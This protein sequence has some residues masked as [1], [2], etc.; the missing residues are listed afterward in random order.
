MGGTP[1][2]M[3]VKS[4]IDLSPFQVK[5]KDRDTLS[6]GQSAVTI[7]GTIDGD[8]L[9]GKASVRMKQGRYSNHTLP[10]VRSSS[11]IEYGKEETLLNDLLI[12]TQDWRSSATRIGITAPGKDAGYI[13]DDKR[14]GYTA[15]RQGGRAQ[16]V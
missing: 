14:A 5:I 12:E 7:D 4:T 9:L 3:A 10:E 1:D 6:L 11:S 13:L 2:R 8:T 15:P 16:T